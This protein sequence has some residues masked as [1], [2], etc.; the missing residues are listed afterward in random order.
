MSNNSGNKKILVLLFVLALVPRLASAVFSSQ[1]LS[2]DEPGYS[3]LAIRILEGKEY[4]SDFLLGFTNAR[5]PM[6]P[7]FIAI[8][9]FFTNNS[10]L[11]VKVIQALLGAIISLSTTKIGSDSAAFTAC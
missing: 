11:A 1:V 5:P 4:R 8:I 6:Y 2:G 3:Q 10:I 9:Y 7:I